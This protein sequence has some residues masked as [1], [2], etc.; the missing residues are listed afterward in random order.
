VFA[1]SGEL[2]SGKTCFVRGIAAGLGVPR[3]S[4]SSP[5]FA[6]IHEYKGR[7]RLAHVDLYRLPSP[8][9]SRELGLSD[10]ADDTTVMAVEW[11]ELGDGDLPD[12]RLDVRFISTGK[13]VREI[14]FQAKGSASAA[15][16]ARLMKRAAQQPGRRRPPRRNHGPSRRARAR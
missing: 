10:Y 15:L 5:T 8:A 11:S 6:F 4:V 2:G 16:L 14:R 7:L 1:I 9:A 13:T 12:D 3:L